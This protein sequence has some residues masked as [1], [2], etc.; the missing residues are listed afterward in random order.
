MHCISASV[1]RAVVRLPLL[2]LCEFEILFY[3]IFIRLIAIPVPY[4]CE[5]SGLCHKGWKSLVKCAGYSTAA[6]AA[7]ATT[8]ATSAPAAATAGC[9]SD[10]AISASSYPV[11]ATPTT[12]SPATTACAISTN[13]WPQWSGCTTTR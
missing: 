1:V 11:T 13:K 12:A 5:V 9:S 6:T 3:N 8:T 2:G 7:A 4:D 10:A